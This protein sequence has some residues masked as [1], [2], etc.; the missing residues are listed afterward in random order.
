MQS[1]TYS[2]GASAVSSVVFYPPPLS[3]LSSRL[4]H[5]P[6]GVHTSCL[7]ANF[8]DGTSVDRSI[9]TVI[10][11]ISSLI[12]SLFDDTSITL[13][14]PASGASAFRTNQSTDA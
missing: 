10:S 3:N 14:G 1:I 4:C 13:N 12:V 7:S 11:I 6:S 5:G 8:A 9:D 2:H